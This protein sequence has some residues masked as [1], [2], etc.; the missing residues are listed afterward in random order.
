M[1]A[2]T[3]TSDIPL[4]TT[5]EANQAQA[6]YESVVLRV[7]LNEEN[8]GKKL[9]M[10]IDTHE[11]WIDRSKQEIEVSWRIRQERPQARLFGFRIGYDAVYGY[12]GDPSRVGLP[13]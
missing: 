6:Y 3:L 1:A 2:S 5:E 9:V 12:F 4:I 13:R 11:Y 7:V 10:D 8:F